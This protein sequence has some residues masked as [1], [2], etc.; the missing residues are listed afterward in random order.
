[1]DKTIC[2]R[3]DEDT[4]R[5]F[6]LLATLSRKNRS[7]FLRRIIDVA[8]AKPQLVLPEGFDIDAYPTYKRYFE[9][10]TIAHRAG[11][12]FFEVENGH[13]K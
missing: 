7:Q 9:K 13:P 6:L 11:G 5:L 1:M 2:F 3:L 4:L 12:D 8:I 10:Y